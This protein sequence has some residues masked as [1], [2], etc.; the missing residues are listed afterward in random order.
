MTRRASLLIV[1]IVL[2]FWCQ[3]EGLE[4]HSHE[5]DSGGRVTRLGPGRPRRIRK[6]TNTP[7]GLNNIL[8]TFIQVLGM[9]RDT[10]EFALEVLSGDEDDLG[11]VPSSD[12]KKTVNQLLG[13]KRRADVVFDATQINAAILFA[14]LIDFDKACDVKEPLLGFRE[15]RDSTSETLAQLVTPRRTMLEN[16]VVAFNSGVSDFLK[17]K[18]SE[19][20]SMSL[21]NCNVDIGSTQSN[22]ILNAIT[23]AEGAMQ[24]SAGNPDVLF[25]FAEAEGIWRASIAEDR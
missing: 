22:S 21:G 8:E 23:E 25:G 13:E 12:I 1:C 14:Q 17:L 5:V 16:L 9:V 7:R 4:Q 2:S 11:L 6:A 10:E 20:M 15:W 24:E 19:N 3:G 18:R